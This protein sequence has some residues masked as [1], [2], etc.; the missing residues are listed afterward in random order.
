MRYLL[1]VWLLI[2]SLLIAPLAAA[3]S[4]PV[5]RDAYAGFSIGQPRGWALNYSEGSIVVT[6]DPEQMIGVLVYPARLMSDMSADQF[7]GM[8]GGAIGDVIRDAGGTFEMAP[9]QAG[10]AAAR[11]TVDGVAMRAL[12]TVKAE[13]GFV[14]VKLIFAPT[15][16]WAAEEPTLQQVAASF[17]R[18]TVVDPGDADGGG[19]IPGKAPQRS[20]VMQPY[21]GRWFR[22]LLPGGWRVVNESDRGIDVAA[23]DRTAFVSYAYAANMT[24]GASLDGLARQL[25][26]LA[27]SGARVLKAS[28]LPSPGGGWQVAAVE[29]SG[30]GFPGL[31]YRGDVHGV[32][33][34]ALL[35]NGFSHT[36]AA[37]FRACAAD[38]WA[39]LKTM[40][41][42]IQDGTAVTST[43]G[44]SNNVMLP[45]NNPADSS[46]IMSSWD[47][48]NRS[49]D[50]AMGNFSN[51]TL[52][53]ER[54]QSPTTG[55]TYTVPMNSWWGTG[56]Q[57]PGY[58]RDIPNGYERL[59][60]V[61]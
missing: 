45:R 56:P 25:L 23:G 55:S 37:A 30:A 39:T 24:G 36:F 42:T 2:V 52:G 41:G 33:T 14:T 1:N 40:L 51:A 50:R 49:G 35:N 26:P 48:K 17:R 22:T 47:Y 10:R 61:K 18:D 4:M 6:R 9:P 54:V 32:L 44:P 20:R 28:D 19:K 43:D 21:Q 57:G 29:F 58:Y 53:I 27:V 7:A 12:L 60:V 16:R 34:V 15:A 5:Y 8:F 46:S 31:G 38:R 13:P 3:P 11:G 59:D